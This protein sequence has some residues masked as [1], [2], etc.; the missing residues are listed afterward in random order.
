MQCRRLRQHCMLIPLSARKREPAEER[1]ENLCL[2]AI[3]VGICKQAHGSPHDCDRLVNDRTGLLEHCAFRLP[4]STQ[5]LLAHTWMNDGRPSMLCWGS[6]LITK[7]AGPA[8]TC[9]NSLAHSDDGMTAGELRCAWTRAQ[10]WD[11]L[12]L[13]YTKCHKVQICSQPAT[14]CHKLPNLQPNCHKLPHLQP[15]WAACGMSLCTE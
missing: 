10:V 4:C 2:S 11:T 3:R 14:H 6:D 13:C 5:A 15:N 8:M 9:T 1:K 7:H 12:R